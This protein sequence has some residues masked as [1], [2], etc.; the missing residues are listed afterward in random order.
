MKDT[1]NM[2]IQ[3]GHEAPVAPPHEQDFEIFVNG[4]KREVTTATLSFDQVVALAFNPVPTDSNILFTITYRHGP[5]ENPQG[6]LLE[7]G[8]VTIKS[9]MVFNV[10]STNRS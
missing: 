4:R 5:K 7:G 1:E 10:T 3:G 6:E 2:G 8:T 9:G